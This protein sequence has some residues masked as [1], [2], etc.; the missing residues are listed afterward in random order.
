MDMGSNVYFREPCRHI[1]AV[2]R[3]RFS[4]RVSRSDLTSGSRRVSETNVD[5]IGKS[6]K[7]LENLRPSSEGQCD[8]DR[9]QSASCLPSLAQRDAPGEQRFRKS[10]GA[11][12]GRCFLFTFTIALT[13]PHLVGL[14]SAPT[15]PI[16]PRSGRPYPSAFPGQ[17]LDRLGPSYLSCFAPDMLCD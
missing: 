6:I 17:L 2:R 7:H 4:F 3:P 12:R 13:V 9:V 8:Q 10:K 15:S 11:R 16:P 1:G 5:R 14:F